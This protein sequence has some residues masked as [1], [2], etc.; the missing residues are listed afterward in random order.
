MIYS[1]EILKMLDEAEK[2][3]KDKDIQDIIGILRFKIE[4]FRLCEKAIAF[5]S[6]E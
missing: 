5:S 2:H 3:Y 4:I 6:K 1:D